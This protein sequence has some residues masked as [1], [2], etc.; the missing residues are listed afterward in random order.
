METSWI[1]AIG[2]MTYGIYILTTVFKKTINGMVASWVTMVSYDPP[3]VMVAV[4]PHRYSHQLID[5]SGVFALNILAQHQKDYLDRFK[6]P[7]PSAKFSSIPWV[8][9]KTGSPLLKDCAGY[10]DCKVEKTFQPGNHTLFIGRIIEARRT[11]DRPVLSTL[12]YDGVYLGK[13]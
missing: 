11:E 1:N 13:R 6:G 3:L 4:H 10:L 8:T 2:K 12:D 5:Q 7:D 9:G